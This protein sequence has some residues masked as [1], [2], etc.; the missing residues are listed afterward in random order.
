MTGD[1][2]LPAAQELSFQKVEDLL[3][4]IGFGR[5]SPHQVVHRFLP[6]DHPEEKKEEAGVEPAIR[7]ARGRQ[8]GGVL[9]KGIHDVLTRFAKC[10]NPLPGDPIVGFITRGRGITIHA[11]SCPR[12]AA[13]D[14]QRLVDVQWD[15]T[16]R[17]LYPVKIEVWATDKKGMLAEVSTA[18][19]S[20]ESNILRADILT[21][22]D[23]KGFFQFI[24]E[25]NDTNHLQ[26]VTS[27][28]K[29]IKGVLNVTRSHEKFI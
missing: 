5:V 27:S 13:E 23:R 3:A 7:K 1:K 17:Q 12:I 18:I 8:K 2:L 28:I 6:K 19:T 22:T 15:M 16:D 24:I 25:V 14:A 26:A 11:G 4:T 21:T 10:C 20:A 29:R 9:I